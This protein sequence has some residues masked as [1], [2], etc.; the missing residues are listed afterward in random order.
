M[1][2]RLSTSV[3]DVTRR[4]ETRGELP[5]L[6]CGKTGLDR[7][8]LSAFSDDPEFYHATIS[9]RYLINLSNAFRDG[10]IAVCR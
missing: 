3:D 10:A 4:R 9:G 7:T 8:R 6:I 1:F 5:C 2:G